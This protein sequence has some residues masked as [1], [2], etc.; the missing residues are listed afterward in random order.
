MHEP[1]ADLAARQHGLIAHDQARRAGLSNEAIAHRVARGSWRRVQRGLYVVA[2]AP[3]S[4]LQSVLGAV[5]VCGPNAFA[6][7]ATAARLWGFSGFDDAPIETTVPLGRV[8][9]RGGIRAHRSGT[10]VDADVRAVEGVPTLSAARTV[11][12]LSARLDER[13]L[14]AMVDDGLRRRVLTLPALV[15]SAGRLRSIAPGRSPKRIERV[16]VDR[17]PGYHP[18]DSE[19][20]TRVMRALVDAGLPEPVRQHRVVVDQRVYVVDL[21]YPDQK[22]AIEVDGFDFH[23]ARTEFDRDRTRQND[24]VRVGWTVLRFTSTSTDAEIVRTVA[25]LLFVC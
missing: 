7:H 19:L 2:G 8:V 6:S 1:L 25:P 17:V 9:R 20:E 16:L 23:R 13:A 11:L 24:L 3:A 10:V 12:D 15:A 21:A 4:W 14:G 18:G 22:I 5:L